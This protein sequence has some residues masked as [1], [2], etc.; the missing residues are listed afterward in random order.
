MQLSGWGR[1]PT[2]VA[3][4]IEPV[5]QKSA[6]SHFLNN[7]QDSHIIARGSGRSYGDSALADHILNTR[8]LDNFISLD[9]VKNTVTCGSGVQL[10]DILKKLE[11]SYL[12]YQDEPDSSNKT[13]WKKEKML[14]FK[15]KQFGDDKDRALIKPNGELTYFMTDIIYHLNKIQTQY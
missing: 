8:F 5:S 15:S 1:Y 14:L 2:T 4:I 13:N 9:T 7:T 6:Q 3:E 12:G 11:I 10:K